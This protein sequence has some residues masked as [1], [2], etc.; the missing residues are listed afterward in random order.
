MNSIQVADETFVA[1][2]PAAVGR[3]VSDRASWRRWWPD[4]RLDVVEDRADKGVRWTV[5]G[6]LTGSMEI[7]LEPVLDGVLLH[8]FL[9]AE[10]SGIAAW[11]LAKMNLAKLNHKRRVAGKRMAFEVKSTLE[12]SRPVGVAPGH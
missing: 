1:A 10:P 8:Y 6:P 7:W 5:T 4:L 2:D 11:Q 3:A 12:A 9:H